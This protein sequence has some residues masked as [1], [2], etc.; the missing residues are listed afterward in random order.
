MT[1]LASWAVRLSP[2]GGSLVALAGIATL[3]GWGWGLQSATPPLTAVTFAVVGLALLLQMPR[4]REIP[5]LNP[6]SRAWLMSAS[7]LGA[8]AVVVM[9]GLRLAAYLIPNPVFQWNGLAFDMVGGQAVRTSP[10]TALCF[11]L[12]G[13]AL[14]ATRAGPVALSHGLALGIGLLAWL[15]VT[16]YLYGG[17]PLPFAHM[18]V[19]TACVF[20]VL[21]ISLLALRLDSSLMA[22]L[23]SDT[24]EARLA[25]QLLAVILLVPIFLGWLQLRG[26][27]L[28]WYGPEAGVSL[29]VLA[30][31]STFGLLVWGSVQ[32]LRSS[33]VERQYARGD[34]R[35]KQQLLQAVA[36]HSPAVIYAKD[37][38]GHYLFV[39]RRFE[40]VF[41]LARDSVL[42]QTDHDLFKQEIAEALRSA[43]LQAAQNEAPVSVEELAPHPDA[44]HTYLSVKSR[45]CDSAGRVY[46]TMGVSTDI[47]ARKLAEAALRESEERFRTLA[48]SVPQLAWTFRPDGRCDFLTR[49]WLEYTGYPES[50]QS[51]DG[52]AGHVHAEDRPRVQSQWAQAVQ[53]GDSFDTEFRLRRADGVFRW[54]RM[55]AIPLRNEGGE[56]TKWFG[57][58]IDVE[59]YKRSEERLRTQL[60]RLHL[61]D[62]TTQ[63]IAD[64]QDLA[65]IS[66]AV[67]RSMEDHLP[68]DF[69]CICLYERIGE[70]LRVSSVGAKSF[71]LATELAMGEQSVI[72]IDGN[73]LA[74]CVRGELVYEPDVSEVNFPFPQR[75]ARGGL[76]AFVAAPL[77]VEK[78]VFGVMVIARHEASSF[79]SPDCEF[80]A[81]LSLHVGLAVHQTRLYTAL[82][83]AY[84]D[85]RQT[86]KTILQQERLRVVG[87]MA[88]GIA[89]DINN[90]L[91]PAAL[92]AQ[93]LLE[94][95]AG[96]SERQREA[97]K[98]ID[99]AIEEV[100]KTVARLR[101]FYRPNEAEVPVPID[102]NH[103][104]EHVLELTRV[105][106]QDMPQER[107]IVVRP[108]L[109]CDS[110]RPAILASESELHAALT[111]LVLNAID[112]MPQG[113]T[114]TVRSALEKA[115]NT[116]FGSSVF[117]EVCDTGVGMDETTRSRCLEPFFT[118]KGERGTGLGLAMVYGMVQ[119]HG[120]DVAIESAPGHGTSVRLIFPAAEPSVTPGP[121]TQPRVVQ[122][123]RLL[124]VDDDV[125]LRETL[126]NILRED[127]HEVIAADGGQAGIDAFCEQHERHQPVDAIITDLGMPYVD[128]RKVAAF[129][130]QRSPGTPVI[131]LTG[132]G[133]RLLSDNDIPE[134]VDRVLG[135]PPKLQELRAA[136]ADVI[137]PGADPSSP[138][139]WR[140]SDRSRAGLL[141]KGEFPKSHRATE[142]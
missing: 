67:L 37:L 38:D 36:D 27:E 23:K 117:I 71:A 70:V 93:S 108:R 110:T 122:A 124:L 32:R 57:T 48:E 2:V 54:F 62:R 22:L 97:L 16:H 77:L 9:A 91:S 83:H 130:K 24:R 131:L 92:Y 50:S 56:I 59:D 14:L 58:N 107:G 118:T 113:G 105:R 114:L 5:G 125:L 63:A 13:L 12:A 116:G 84:D 128:G 102:I 29:F 55:R 25:R 88:S 43:D 136:L 20:L 87:Q 82:Q 129:I 1:V 89:H 26:E 3:A 47:T 132:W 64:R 86:Q 100:S 109:E 133:H 137:A 68:V 6:R 121:V 101:E 39:N 139:E 112:A 138:A 40:E 126:I 21:S 76:R 134:N 61:L 142:R 135:K 7:S 95:S 74:R 123:L 18:T 111:N 53:R 49:Q 41:G 94:N 119:R 65:S 44:V 35:E 103:T 79:E 19:D 30:S 11:L 66:H 69:A 45:L 96:M 127:G 72:D 60:A 4:H 78:Q 104:L 81:Q 141:M 10:A 17:A 52:W 75:L 106:W 34:A 33:E 15:G 90:A 120:G 140:T 80:L 99:R 73:G 28:E 8:M 98:I 85:L 51:G 46:A 42:G 115:P 31:M